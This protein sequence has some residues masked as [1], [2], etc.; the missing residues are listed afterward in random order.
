MFNFF[1]KKSLKKK[2]EKGNKKNEQVDL[3][4]VGSIGSKIRTN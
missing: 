3:L 2:K 4:K 1:K